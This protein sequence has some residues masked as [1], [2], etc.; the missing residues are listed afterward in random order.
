MSNDSSD[1]STERFS[2][3]FRQEYLLSFS[4][5]LV[6]YGG[7]QLYHFVSYRSSLF[8]TESFQECIPRSYY[9]VSI[10]FVS[11][12]SISDWQLSHIPTRPPWNELSYLR[13]SLALRRNKIHLKKD[14]S[15]KV[16]LCLNL[17]LWLLRTGQVIC[18]WI[19][20][21]SAFIEHGDTSD[22]VLSSLYDVSI[23][24][25][26]SNFLSSIKVA[27]ADGI[28]VRT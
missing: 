7:F 25:L 14:R 24:G 21:W 13:D 5:N 17:L 27:V 28:M 19:D 6:L 16:L 3:L 12:N 11:T 22:D 2:F 23:P 4:I 26:I 9:S 18:E 10:Y 15:H 8:M 1:G 20:I